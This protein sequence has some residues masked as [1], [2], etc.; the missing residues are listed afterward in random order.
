[1]DIDTSQAYQTLHK[2]QM[3]TSHERLWMWQH[4]SAIAEHQM[5]G[6]IHLCAHNQRA[7]RTL[8]QHITVFFVYYD[9]LRKP[10]DG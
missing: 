5:F 2:E 8:K 6:T 7:S 9:S 4:A 3:D 10:M 1:M